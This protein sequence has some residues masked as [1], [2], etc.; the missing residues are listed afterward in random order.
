MSPVNL[1]SAGL[2]D[3]ILYSL[4]QKLPFSAVSVG[5]TEAFVLAQYTILRESEFMEHK[6]AYVAN[7]GVKRGFDHRGVRF[8]NIDARNDAVESLAKADAIGYNMLLNCE[9]TNKVLYYYH[10]RPAYVFEALI[11]R[12][13]MFSQPERFNR[14]LANRKILLVCAY[15]DEVQAAMEK[16]LQPSLGFTVTGAVRLEEYEDIPRVKEEID[17]V[18]FDLCLMAAGVNAVILAPYIARRYGKVAFDI[19]QA[20][21]SFITGEVETLGYINRFVG[22][23]VLMSL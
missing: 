18:D 23:D 16:I 3:V 8:P 14:M 15:A 17:R 12:V 2:M 7:Q 10:F 13:V 1:N 11:R 5:T 22:L 19:G 4:D 21:E 6:E 9:L 20:M